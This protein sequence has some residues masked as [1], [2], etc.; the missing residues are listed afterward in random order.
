MQ[1]N[2]VI[3]TFTDVPT[4]V[5]FKM[6]TDATNGSAVTYIYICTYSIADMFVILFSWI[7]LES[8]CVVRTFNF[9]QVW[10]ENCS[11]QM[12]VHRIRSEHDCE[13][14]ETD[15]FESQGNKNTQTHA[16]I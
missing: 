14:C 10:K 15:I 11:S 6:I 3:G 13:K 7:S 1:A 5:H 16:H 12:S 9:S 4:T 8:L 2:V